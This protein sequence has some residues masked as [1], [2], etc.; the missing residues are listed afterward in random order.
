MIKVNYDATTGK[1]L[2]FGKDT[3]PYIDITEAERKQ[4]LPTKY[5]YYAVVDGQF[6]IL[7]RTPSAAETKDDT[8]RALRSQIATLKAQLDDTDYKAIK[9]MEG[10][11]TADEYAECKANR[12]E[13][14]AQI[15]ELE[16]ELANVLSK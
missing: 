2:S 4:P 10:W 15:N 6:K 14:R 12:A 11:L 8:A 7:A 5:H 3:E 16:E 9:F 1:V 13:W